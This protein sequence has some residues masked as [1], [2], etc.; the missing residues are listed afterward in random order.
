MAGPE[1]CTTRFL[2]FAL[3]FFMKILCSTINIII[4]ACIYV[5]IYRFLLSKYKEKRI[6]TKII[7]KPTTSVIELISC[8]Y[9]ISIKFYTDRNC[10][11]RSIAAFGQHVSLV[12]RCK[13]NIALNAPYLSRCFPHCERTMDLHHNH[14]SSSLKSCTIVHQTMTSCP[15]RFYTSLLHYSMLTIN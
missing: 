8:T 11:N 6:N 14:W 7:L 1:Y 12:A 10:K 15:A 4:R 9:S 3:V 5:Y 13:Y 2:Y